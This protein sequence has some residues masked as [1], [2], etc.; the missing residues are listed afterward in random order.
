VS[1]EPS[2]TFGATASDEAEVDRVAYRWMRPL[3]IMAIA[4]VVVI[5]FQTHPAPGGHGEHL[6]V[7][8]S[9]VVL[10]AGTVAIVGLRA[11][12]PQS[13]APL[14]IAVVLSAAALVGVQPN[15]PGFLGVFPAVC[16]AVL[17]LPARLGAAVTAIAGG[18]LVVAW[19]LGGHRPVTGLILN[20]FGVAAFYVL[21][22]FARRLGEANEQARQLIV[23]LEQTRAAQAQA[24]ALGERQRLAREMHDVLA[25]SL[26]GLVL[27]LESA[28]LIAER[29]DGNPRVA[30]AI[31]RAHRLAKSGLEEARW[32]IGM[33]RDDALPGQQRLAELASEFEGDTGVACTFAVNGDQRDLSSDG[34]L[35]IYRVLQEAL[36]NVRK[37]AHPDRVDVRL[38]YEPAGTW[39][40]VEDFQTNS[41][42]LP[43]GDGTG[44]GLTGMRERAELLGGTLATGPTANGY[45]VELWVPR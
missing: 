39:L 18:A 37:H 2:T 21:S 16:V 17:R 20:E 45:R 34:I 3:A 31:E 7:S 1:S 35:T 28:R 10:G 26:S 9:L 40:T 19:A 4:I 42:W 27:N 43:P 11:A 8:I 24:A 32:A 44:Y 29:G 13:F 23:E 6:V 12:T 5:A 14:L 22:M 15:G 30:D 33:L 36:T 25:H 41:H 38:V